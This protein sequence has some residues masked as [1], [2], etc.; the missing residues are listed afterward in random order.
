MKSTINGSTINGSTINRLIPYFIFV[1]DFVSPENCGFTTSYGLRNSLISVLLVG[2]FVFFFWMI[3]SFF[4]PKFQSAIFGRDEVS[5]E[6]TSYENTTSV[7]PREGFNTT[8]AEYTYYPKKVDR[9]QD[10]HAKFFINDFMRD[11]LEVPEC[12]KV[13]K[14]LL[15]PADPNSPDTQPEYST[16]SISDTAVY[17]KYKSDFFDET[18][19]TA[20]LDEVFGSLFKKET[21]IVPKTKSQI[22]ELKGFKQ[23]VELIMNTENKL[24]NFIKYSTIQPFDAPFSFTEFSDY[25]AT[26]LHKYHAKPQQLEQI[27]T[28]FYKLIRPLYLYSKFIEHFISNQSIYTQKDDVLFVINETNELLKQVKIEDFSHSSTDKNVYIFKEDSENVS[29]KTLTVD[30]LTLFSMIHILLQL[31]KVLHPGGSKYVQISDDEF[32]SIFQT[33]LNKRFPNVKTKSIICYALKPSNAPTLV[34]E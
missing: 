19:G 11:V 17:K 6:S 26:I 30:S 3:F 20:M 34:N 12:I 2:L 14:Q 4:F 16:S 24:H 22:V 8:N 29:N 10:R 33:Y 5:Y 25:F 23:K 31:R 28:F 1:R 7:F 32:S 27:K 15:P 13:Y 21:F 18:K 9:I